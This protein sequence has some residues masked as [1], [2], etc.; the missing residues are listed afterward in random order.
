MAMLVL[1]VRED[2]LEFGLESGSV[3]VLFIQN[4]RGLYFAVSLKI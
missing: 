3:S 2:Y 1:V 4:Q